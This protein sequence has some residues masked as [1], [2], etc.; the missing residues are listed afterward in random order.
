MTESQGRKM[1]ILHET[2][3]VSVSAR[4]KAEADKVGKNITLEGKMSR[5]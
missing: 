4:V 3:T 5:N 2:Q 1:K